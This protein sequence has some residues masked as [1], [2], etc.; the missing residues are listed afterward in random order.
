MYGACGLKPGCQCPILIDVLPGRFQRGF[1]ALDPR[2]DQFQ[3][4]R[5]VAGRRE[6]GIMAPARLRDLADR[7]DAVTD[8]L[9]QALFHAPTAQYRRVGTMPD[10]AAEP[11]DEPHARAADRSWPD[12]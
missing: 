7:G 10:Y 11:L 3:E 6:I 9:P 8:A 1:H 5:A 4:D 12:R 2:G